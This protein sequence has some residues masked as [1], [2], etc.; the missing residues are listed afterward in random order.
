[1]SRWL[2]LLESDS[3]RLSMRNVCTYAVVFSMCIGFLYCVWN[4]DGATA[5]GI[6]GILS[7]LI[8]VIYGIGK[9]QDASVTKAINANKTGGGNVPRSNKRV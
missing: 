3:H 1:M 4:D 8:G 9:V 5:I 7:T 6:A 2:E